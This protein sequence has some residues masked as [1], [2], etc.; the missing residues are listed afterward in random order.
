MNIS[1]INI[2]IMKSRFKILE[3]YNSSLQFSYRNKLNKLAEVESRK[4]GS[5]PRPTTQKNPRPR[6]DFPRTD[7]LE[8]KDR[9]AQTRSQKFAM[10][11]GFWGSERRSPKSPEANG[12]LGAEPQAARGWG[13]GAK[14]LSRR[15]HGGLGAEPPALKNFAFF[16]KNNFILV[17]F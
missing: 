5:K 7:P 17:L 4:Q 15:R 6:T 11:G 3:N 1:D 12:G 13:L 16:C 10:G 14:A 2:M 8:A 9:N